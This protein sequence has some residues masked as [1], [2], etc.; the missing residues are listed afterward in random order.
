MKPTHTEMKW[1]LTWETNKNNNCESLLG[2]GKLENPLKAVLILETLQ[3]K[4]MNRKDFKISSCFHK[5]FECNTI[6]E[7]WQL[8]KRQCMLLEWI[9]CYW[10]IIS[11][12]VGLVASIKIQI[13]FQWLKM[14]MLKCT[15][16]IRVSKKIKLKEEKHC[17]GTCITI[18]RYQHIRQRYVNKK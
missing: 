1:A 8:V 18:T 11:S 17:W 10:K 4:D 2:V 12:W 5:S 6:T 9:S 16:K 13:N 15:R 7:K 14:F 3:G